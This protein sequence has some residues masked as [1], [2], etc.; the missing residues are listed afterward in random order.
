MPV[1]RLTYD[2]KKVVE[3]V[4]NTTSPTPGKIYLFELDAKDEKDNLYRLQVSQNAIIPKGETVVK[5]TSNYSVF[6]QKNPDKLLAYITFVIPTYVDSGDFVIGSYTSPN[7][8]KITIDESPV[9]KL[10]VKI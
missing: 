3:S 7:G 8:S 10:C 4:F 1:L 5:Q 6:D 9:R 2:V